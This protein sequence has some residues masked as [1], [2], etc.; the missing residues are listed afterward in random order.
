MQQGE[1]RRWLGVRVKRGE[2]GLA[3]ALSGFVQVRDTPF[4]AADGA[5]EGIALEVPL[6]DRQA[7][8]AALDRAVGAFVGS[9]EDLDWAVP[10]ACRTRVSVAR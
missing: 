5:F 9:A 7:E 8:R 4:V 2:N 3:L 1:P 10:A 6:G